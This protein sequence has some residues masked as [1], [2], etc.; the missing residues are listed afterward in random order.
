MAR[1]LDGLFLDNEQLRTSI[2]STL[3][4]MIGFGDLIEQRELNADGPRRI[5]S[6][7]RIRASC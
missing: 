4:A 5:C 6:I 3:D 1:A 2:E 7:Q